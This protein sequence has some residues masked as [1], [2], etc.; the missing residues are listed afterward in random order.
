[1]NCEMKERI[2]GLHLRWE[3]RPHNKNVF[4][5]MGRETMMH[6]TPAFTSTYSYG[7][8]ASSSFLSLSVLSACVGNA[9]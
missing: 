8:F 1:M 7:L 2:A 4:Q 6:I 5:C 9:V 3:V